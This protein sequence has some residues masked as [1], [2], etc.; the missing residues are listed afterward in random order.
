MYSYSREY[1][2]VLQSTN[3]GNTEVA[4]KLPTVNPIHLELE[5]DWSCWV[6]S[7]LRFMRSRHRLTKKKKSRSNYLTCL[8]QFRLPES[9]GRPPTDHVTIARNN[10]RIPFD[11]D[12]RA[13]RDALQAQIRKWKPLQIGSRTQYGQPERP[14][15][16]FWA[17]S[18]AVR[19]RSTRNR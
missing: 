19:S 14:L 5:T 6:N 10:E 1:K 4:H 8:G 11:S 17:E 13:L 2:S 15:P 3:G 7:G 18:K 12:Y 16:I 9:I